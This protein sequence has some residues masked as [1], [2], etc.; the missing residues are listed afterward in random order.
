MVHN[1]AFSAIRRIAPKKFPPVQEHTAVAR[2]LKASVKNKYNIVPIG[3]VG[4]KL[5]FL[6]AARHLC[7]NAKILQLDIG[8][9]KGKIVFDYAQSRMGGFTSI[10]FSL[11][12]GTQKQSFLASLAIVKGKEEET[13][14][15]YVE[16]AKQLNGNRLKVPL[17][18]GS[19][20]EIVIFEV[21]DMAAEWKLIKMKKV[22]AFTW[23]PNGVTAEYDES[24]VKCRRGCTRCIAVRVCPECE[25]DEWTR[26]NPEEVLREGCMCNISYRSLLK[27]CNPEAFT[28]E[29]GFTIKHQVPDIVHYIKDLV[30]PMMRR[31]AWVGV[32]ATGSLEPFNRAL[33]T[34]FGVQTALR[35]R[36][37][38]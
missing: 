22:I 7:T 24:S 3:N 34:A 14:E 13:K 28:H 2:Q 18:D 1:V 35:V 36:L 23:S 29:A 38:S 4:S 25:R 21:N 32:Q 17:A 11:I 8:C 19:E 31:I 20:V 33:K 6:T 30:E 26:Q 37:L 12:T 5:N 9:W 10:T 15:T 16:F 27:T